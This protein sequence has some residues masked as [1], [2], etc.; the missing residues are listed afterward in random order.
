[1]KQTTSKI[2]SQKEAASETINILQ[3]KYEVAEKHSDDIKNLQEEPSFMTEEEIR[4]EERRTNEKLLEPKIIIEEVETLERHPDYLGNNHM[5]TLQEEI[6][7][8]RSFLKTVEN[9]PE[10]GTS[11]GDEMYFLIIF[12]YF[13]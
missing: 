10:D 9:A 1:M 4:E 8:K 13:Y 7:K 5:K 6:E 12:C 11:K 3:S 2:N